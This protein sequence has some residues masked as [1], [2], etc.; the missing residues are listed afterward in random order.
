MTQNP[1]LKNKAV[2]GFTLVEILVVIAITAVLAAI[3]IPVVGGV[4]TSSLRSESANNLRQLY[5]ACTLYSNDHNLQ[6]ANAFIAANEEIGREQ[7]GWWNQLV[8]GGYLGDHGSS[9]REF[10]VLGSPIQ[11]REVPEITIDQ[12]PPVYPTYGMNIVLSM[13]GRD[14][15]SSLRAANSLLLAEHFLFQ[16]AI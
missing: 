2:N 3:L 15:T 10:E 12:D 7:S 4:M 13:I 6:L 5:A 1:T 16:R 14:E 9:P 11:R 8:D